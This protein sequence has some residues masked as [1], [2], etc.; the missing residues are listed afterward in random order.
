MDDAFHFFHHSLFSPDSRRLFFLHRWVDANARLWTRMFS[1][2]PDGSD[3]FLFPMDEMVS[4]VTWASPSEVFGYVR[5]PGQG[6]GYYLIEDRTGR[7]TRFF[8][9]VL[10]P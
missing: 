4:H 10:K 8:E 1:A 2:A 9:H 7:A 5:Y 3:L 6:D